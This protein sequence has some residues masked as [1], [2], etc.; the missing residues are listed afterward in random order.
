[1]SPKSY[2][3]RSSLIASA[4]AFS[5]GLTFAE[6]HSKTTDMAATAPA[7]VEFADGQVVFRSALDS[8]PMAFEYRTDQVLTPQ[9]EEFYMFHRFRWG[10]R[11][12]PCTRS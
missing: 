5:A 1:M 11:Y 3:L 8:A 6:S 4:F 9:V 12:L 2:V 7:D 10:Q